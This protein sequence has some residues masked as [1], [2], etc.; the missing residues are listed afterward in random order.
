MNFISEDV[1][2]K[3]YG[4]RNLNETN[5]TTIPK[6]CGGAVCT[7][8]RYKFNPAI[9]ASNN[10]RMDSGQG[11]TYDA[12]GNT[13]TDA[14]SQSYMYDGENKQVK[15]SNGGGT[16]GEYFYD[17]DGKRVKKVVP[18][19]GETTVFVYD[20]AG[21]QPPTT[22]SPK[23]SYPSSRQEGADYSTAGPQ[24]SYSTFQCDQA[25][26]T[27]CYRN[28]YVDIRSQL[29]GRWGHLFLGFRG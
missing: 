4:N 14:N 22:P 11:Y 28:S 10:N 13:L 21:K 5:T 25:A 19:T 27:V 24:V 8:D 20:A 3:R 9:N 12:A 1:T 7:A 23:R 6:N 15:A 16:L 17:G 29:F 2:A 26:L 18:S